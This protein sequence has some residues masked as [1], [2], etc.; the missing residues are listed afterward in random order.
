MA[1]KLKSAIRIQ[2]PWPQ[3]AICITLF[4]LP[5]IYFFPALFGKVTL[6][7]GDGWTQ[8]FGIRILVGRMIA[9][10]E[11]PLWNP[12]IFA[13]MPLLASIQPGALYP[14]TWL[15]A[16]LSP[17]TAMNVLV[18]TT[19]HLALFG[20]YLFARR[21]GCNRVGAM[22]SAVT[23]SF[24][25]YM[26]AHLGHTNRINAAAW[27]PWIL[28]AIESCGTTCQVVPGQAGSLSHQKLWRWVTAGALFIALQIFAGDPQMTLY[29]AMT[30]AA[31]ALFLLFRAEPKSR[32]KFAAALAAMAICGA[33]LSMI[34]LLPARELLKL[35][36]RAGID[37]Q[38]FAQFSFPPSQLLALFFP[39][40][41]GGAATAPYSV[42][43]WGK[44]NLTETCGYVGMA[45]WLLAFAA[46][47]STGGG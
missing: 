22:I 44:W 2:K 26:L 45:A 16:V 31:Y 5:L 47:Y 42:P 11:L 27:L 10:G 28:L 32:A 8:I 43:Y 33:L 3:S 36:D 19:Y 29:T 13:G 46:W 6:A 17:Q 12:Y 18:L 15:F 7:P 21:I 37:Y 9:A 20:T 39:Y 40:F 35:G 1:D 34:Q 25:G 41:F 38:Y 24:G 4:L 30:A 14:P 23:F